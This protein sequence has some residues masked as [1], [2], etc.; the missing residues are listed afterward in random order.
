MK[1]SIL[2]FALVFGVSSVTFA[3]EETWLSMGYQRAFYFDT[4]KN[5]EADMDTYTISQGTNL[6]VYRFLAD[7]VGIFVN[8]SLLLFLTNRWEDKENGLSTIDLSGYA[9]NS[10]TGLT[11]GIV[12]KADVTDDFKAYFGIGFDYLMTGV[13]YPGSGNVSYSK[14]TCD[15][16]LGV[17]TG[18][19]I[20]LTDRFFVR[21]GSTATCNF[22]RY[23]E[24]DT[25]HG[26]RKAD[27]VSGWE[28][29][30]LMLS[31]RPYI[32][33]GLNLFWAENNGRFRLTTGKE[34]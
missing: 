21:V 34:K 15:L 11:T 33:L 20:D 23:T 25:Y 19:K 2:F 7:N 1:K 3:I 27:G 6:S 4:Y 24:L 14:L 8:A 12:F 22:A 17:D 32:S 13:V 29:E 28:Q 31:A 5:R 26:R 18:I 16:G 9:L 10:Q 30:F